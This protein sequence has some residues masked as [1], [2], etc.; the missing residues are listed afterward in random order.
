MENVFKNATL[1]TQDFYQHEVYSEYIKNL[2]YYLLNSKRNSLVI[3]FFH[4][5][6]KESINK[7]DETGVHN[8]NK[9]I[10]SIYNAY[11]F[12]PTMDAQ[13]IM[14]QIG[15]NDAR[16]GHDINSTNTITLYQMEEPLPD[17]LFYF[18][19]EP[20]EIFRVTAVQ[21]IQNIHKDLKLYQLTFENANVIK[22][23]VDKL[24]I[25]ETYY[26]NNEFN[27]WFPSDYYNE[28]T[29]LIKYKNILIKNIKRYYNNFECFFQDKTLDT[30]TI[31]K[32]NEHINL[33]RNLASVDLPAQIG[34]KFNLDQYGYPKKFEVG[35]IY[36]NDPLYVPVVPIVPDP[37]VYVYDPYEGKL[38]NDLLKNT[39]IL[40]NLYKPF[41][42][43]KLGLVPS[44]ITNNEDIAFFENLEEEII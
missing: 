34:Y 8:V 25:K 37:L 35:E 6:V 10:N 19:S 30:N 42:E 41:I 5:D 40:Y 28:F 44:V 29:N 20:K 31:I 18:Y 1:L 22:E 39:Y 26:F 14:Y 2:N 12:C 38:K 15:R 36:I 23:T 13:Q 16:L 3:K 24:Q 4:M 11:E 9:Y 43:I 27:N 7:D 17:D 32:V 33:L 21:F